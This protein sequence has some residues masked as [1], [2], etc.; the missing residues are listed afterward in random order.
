MRKV[1]TITNHL[2]QKFDGV[3][4][5]CRNCT[6]S[7]RKVGCNILAHYQFCSA[8][9]G[10]N[11]GLGSGIV[12]LLFSISPFSPVWDFLWDV[13]LKTPRVRRRTGSASGA[14][15]NQ[16]SL[17]EFWCVFSW[18]CYPNIAFFIFC[19]STFGPWDLKPHHKLKFLHH[20]RYGSVRIASGR[21]GP[22]TNGV[23]C[24]WC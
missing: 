21:T 18:L 8:P 1:I 11:P 16:L 15:L 19:G 24:G 10:M 4:H 20:A 13:K 6:A 12:F 7:G 5:F 3:L 14:V 17:T 22:L 2:F 23:C 9:A